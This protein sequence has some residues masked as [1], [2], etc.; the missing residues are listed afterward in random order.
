MVCKTVAWPGHHVKMTTDLDTSRGEAQPVLAGGCTVHTGRTLHYTGGN[1]QSEALSLVQICPDT[2]LSLVE[3][4][5]MIAFCA[6]QCV[7]M[8]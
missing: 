3:P 2:L 6:F 4:Y 1:R 8:A 7:V 5:Y